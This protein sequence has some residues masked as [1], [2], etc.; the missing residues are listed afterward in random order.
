MKEDWQGTLK[1]DNSFVLGQFSNGQGEAI[2]THRKHLVTSG[3]IF[4]YHHS[5][6]AT[7]IWWT[8]ARDASNHPVTQK[9]DPQINNYPA[10]NVNTAEIE[11]SCNDIVNFLLLYF[12]QF[13]A[14]LSYKIKKWNKNIKNYH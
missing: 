9:M 10:P 11:T 2:L 1:I 6:G 14:I 8:E 13:Y 3:A 7:G 4:D 5:G 12:L